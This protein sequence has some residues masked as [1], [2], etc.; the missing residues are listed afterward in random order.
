MSAVSYGNNAV[1]G[2]G[3]VSGKIT[4]CLGK[5]GKIPDHPEN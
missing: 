4:F 3:D 2:M 1:R 5:C